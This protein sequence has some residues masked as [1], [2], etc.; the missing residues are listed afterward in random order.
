MNLKEFSGKQNEYRLMI[1]KALR[2]KFPKCPNQTMEDA[3]SEA[4]LKMLSRHHEVEEG[5]VFETLVTTT[6]DEL[7]KYYSE[8]KKF[9][10][11][12]IEGKRHHDQ[13]NYKK[14]HP[15]FINSL[16]ISQRKIYEQRLK[17]TPPRNMNV[18][19]T[20]N[21]INVQTWLIL[22]KYKKWLRKR[23]REAITDYELNHVV[24]QSK[25]RIM[26]LYLQGYSPTT[27]AG[28]TSRDNVTISSIIYGAKRLIYRYRKSIKV[29]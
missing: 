5:K 3:Y 6:Y 21:C 17:K 29:L 7:S 9:Q 18:G 22:Q 28:M 1:Y 20:K 11:Y 15:Y 27:I 10:R 4:V 19:M 12:V 8:A 16:T 2:K 26:E 23:K 14:L 13:L 25:R 24:P